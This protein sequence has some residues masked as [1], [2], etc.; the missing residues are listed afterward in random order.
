LKKVTGLVPD[1]VL[2]SERLDAHKALKLLQGEIVWMLSI[3]LLTALVALAWIERSLRFGIVAALPAIFGV[4][5][6]VSLFSLL[7]RPLT[8]VASAG[9]TLVM[10]LGI[11]YGIFMQPRTG[12][13]RRDTAGAVTAS[14]LTTLAAFGVLSI[15]KV[16]AMADLGLI[17]LTGVSAAVLA[18]LFVVPIF[19]TR[20]VQ[21]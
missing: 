17:I 13:V 19:N 4:L 16:N 15:A 11:D 6:A 7:G 3:W 12:R 18:A 8:A 9:V 10:G 2:V 14:A 1:C 5:A 21:K 20:S